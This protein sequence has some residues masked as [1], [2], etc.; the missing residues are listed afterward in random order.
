ME[1][2]PIIAGFVFIAFGSFMIYDTYTF[3][4]IAD[5]VKGKLLGYEHHMSRSKNGSTKMYTPVVEF[6]YRETYYCFKATISTSRMSYEIGEQVSVLLRNNDPDNARLKTNS[7]YWLGGLFAFMGVIALAVGVVNFRFDKLS[8]LIAAG[9]LLMI[10]FQAV[11][12]KQKLE[13]KNINSL[14]ELIDYKAN[15][16]SETVVDFPVTDSLFVEEGG[17]SVSSNNY[18]PTAELI[19]KK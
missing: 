6:D 18:Q 5:E 19:T 3:R 12:F 17:R 16:K 4:K 11:S 2:I 9:L 14:R 1:I 10:A 13:D 15:K 8:L 7:R